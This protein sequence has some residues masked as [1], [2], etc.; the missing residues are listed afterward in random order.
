MKAKLLFTSF[1]LLLVTGVHSQV[2]SWAKSLSGAGNK[3]GYSNAVDAAGNQYVTGTFT[4]VV[5]FDPG[6]GTFWLS[7]YGAEDIFVMKLNKKGALV[8]AVRFSGYA[9][10][11]SRGIALDGNGNIYVVG[12]FTDNTDFDPGPGV[13]ALTSAGSWDV[14]VT[15][16]DNAGNLLWVKQFAGVTEEERGNA[17]AVDAAGNVY[18]T[19]CFKGTIDF[20]PGAGSYPLTAEYIDVF[21]SK[22]DTDGNF[23]WA[24]NMGGQFTDI[25]ASIAVDAAGNVYTTG[26]FK[27]WA[28]F[29]P[30]PGAF[31]LIYNTS[32]ADV[33][34]CKLSPTGTLVW[35]KQFTS[36]PYFECYGHALALDPSGNV[37]VTGKFY[38]YADFDTGPAK[39]LLHAS[40]LFDGFVCKLNPSGDFLWANL[41]GG[42]Q[43]EDYGSAITCDALGNVYTM[44]V[45]KYFGDFDPGPG[46]VNLYAAGNTDVFISK[47]SPTGSLVWARRVVGGT[48]PDYGYSMVLDDLQHIYIT[49]SFEGNADMDPSTTNYVLSTPEGQPDLFAVKLNQAVWNGKI[50]NA[51]GTADNWNSNVVPG[52]RHDVVIPSGV[53]RYPLAAVSTEIRSLTLQSGASATV[54]TGSQI[55]IN[56]QD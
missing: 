39:F 55:V 26:Y 15:K 5:D 27:G 42:C 24:A 38:G 40:G 19:G 6:P 52:V 56:S 17:I 54:A 13:V 46:T 18:T 8:W 22:L 43:D 11:Q 21:V 32:N 4:G 28:D 16:L 3:I 50:S 34:I 33:F 7:S 31:W 35:A 9:S 1:I 30:G 47:Q 25:G 41:A 10:E 23:V 48:S 45:F 36:E 44:G 20:N 49:G 12:H 51:W 53:S 29:D 37:F 2:L 14:F